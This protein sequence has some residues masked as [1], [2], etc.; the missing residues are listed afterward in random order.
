M[1]AVVKILLTLSYVM[2]QFYLAKVFDG[3]LLCS[4]RL[5]GYRF[6]HRR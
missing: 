3:N 4:L 6:G 1:N 5:L 2:F